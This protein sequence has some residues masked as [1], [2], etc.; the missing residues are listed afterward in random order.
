[1][2]THDDVPAPR[3]EP[4][5]ILPKAAGL[6]LLTLLLANG[7]ATTAMKGTPFYSGEYAGTKGLPEDRVNLWPLAYYS[8]PALSVL[9][10]MGERTDTSLAFRPLLSLYRD[11][12]GE[13]YSEVNALWPL[14][15]FSLNGNGS[16]VFPVFWG[17]DYFHVAPLYWHDRRLDC[18]FPL[19]IYQPYTY[20]YKLDILWPFFNRYHYGD[21]CHGL[22]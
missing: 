13:P 21:S 17:K 15:H 20:G 5:G 6:L 14:A 1:M 22:R 9:W 19:W 12:P 2:T 3:R 18:L 16:H 11:R 10:P 7:C 4:L 8:D